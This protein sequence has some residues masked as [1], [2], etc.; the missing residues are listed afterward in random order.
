MKLWFPYRIVFDKIYL[1]SNSHGKD[2]TML[3][4]TYLYVRLDNFGT[5]RYNMIYG[6]RLWLYNQKGQ[7]IGIDFKIHKLKDYK[8]EY[9][10]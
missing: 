3:K 2:F 5:K 9:T 6:R 4:S 1:D 8:D 7:C 10:P